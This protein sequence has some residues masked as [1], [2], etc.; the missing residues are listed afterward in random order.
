M[1]DTAI[2]AMGLLVFSLVF[3]GFGFTIWEVRRIERN[4]I[5]KRR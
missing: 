4:T 1:S 5:A 3:G 2:F